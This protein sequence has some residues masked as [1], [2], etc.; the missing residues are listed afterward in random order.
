MVILSDSEREQCRR[1][2]FPHWTLL[3]RFFVV[4]LVLWSVPALRAE[5][6]L[7]AK[8]LFSAAQANFEQGL[9]ADGEQRRMLMIKA[10][11]QFQALMDEFGIENGYIYYNLGNAYY[12]AGDIGR[13]VLN[14]RRAERLVP[15]FSDLQ[16]NLKQARDRLGLEKTEE[17][18]STTVLRS[19][20][21]WHTMLNYELRR[22]LFALFFA[23]FW[24]L[25]IVRIFR[26]H[27]FLRIGLILFAAMS[28]GFGGSYLH[29]YYQLHGVDA[30]VVTA[31]R[32]TARKGPGAGYDAFYSKPLPG[33]T[34]F[35]ILEQSSAWWKVALAIGDVVWI[36]QDDAASI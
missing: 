16:Y 25:L 31:E 22:L 6:N 28:F 34:E 17:S 4:V 8:A 33:G 9:N 29:S 27:I 32:T 7:D 35:V 3:A 1:W 10:A 26:R 2:R 15:G 30:G 11:G 23:L 19:L 13:A 24:V 21:F 12:E 14:Y 36:R 5:T 20:L 18:W